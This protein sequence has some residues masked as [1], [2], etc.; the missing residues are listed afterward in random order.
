MNGPLSTG[1]IPTT[2]ACILVTG[3]AG[4]IGAAVARKLVDARFRVRV[5]DD[6]SRGSERRLAGLSV[7]TIIDDIRSERAVR[8]ACDGVSGI[9]HLA[10]AEP[11]PRTPRDELIA[12]EINVTGTLHVCSAARAH[13][14]HRAVLASTARVYG[15]HGRSLLHEE[16]APRP[17]SSEGAQK[18]AAETYVRL[19]TERDHLP[20]CILRI[21]SAYGPKEQTRSSDDF[22]TTF[23][24]RSVAGHPATIAGDGEQTRTLV[25]VDD[26][27]EAV[28]AALTRPGVTGRTFNVASAE[29]PSVRH[30][31]GC[32]GDI[33]GPLPAPRFAPP[34][35]LDPRHVRASTAAAASGLGFVARTPLENGLRACIAGCT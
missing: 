22:V 25:Y 15:D 19:A 1:R 7:D 31:L 21:F 24:A 16:S 29:S 3:G 20:A 12:H 23:V 14:V 30:V 10:A 9:V 34:R 4:F 32:I 8:D 28:V 5:L 13:G 27:A 6:M 35:L 2:G 33:L 26:V 11:E 18:L 17:T